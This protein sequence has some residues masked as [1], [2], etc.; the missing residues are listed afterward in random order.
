MTLLTIPLSSPPLP[1]QVQTRLKYAK[2]KAVEIDRC[3]KCGITPTP[4]PPGGDEG[5]EFNLGEADANSSDS[6]DVPPPQYPS[7]TPSS[8]PTPSPDSQKPVPKPRHQADTSSAPPKLVQQPTPMPPPPQAQA[9]SVGSAEI[10]RAQK[11]CK[12]ASSALDYQDVT[13]A[14]DFLQ[15]AI[16]LLQTGKEE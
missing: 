1:F 3:L 4:G 2:W 8:V 13:G 15:K 5:G 11:L 14:V 10:S 12:F 6:S 7:I 9:K 16:K